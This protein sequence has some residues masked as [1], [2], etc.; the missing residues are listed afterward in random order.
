M[1]KVTQRVIE[2]G[3]KKENVTT[4]DLPFIIADV[5]GNDRSIIRYLLRTIPFPS[6]TD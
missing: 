1:T 3:D 4:E 2:L 5:L 6:L